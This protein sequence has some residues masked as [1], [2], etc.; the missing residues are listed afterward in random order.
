MTKK[1]SRKFITLASL[2]ILM[3]GMS[4]NAKAANITSLASGN[5]STTAT[6]VGGVVPV[7]GDVVTIA[8]GH[9]ITVTAN[10]A[11]ASVSFAG[12]T[13][14]TLTISSGFTLTVSGDVGIANTV[15]NVV[16]THTISG[17]GTLSCANLNITNGVGSGNGQSTNLTSNVTNLSVSGALTVGSNTKQGCTASIGGTTVN[18]G[19]VSV[20]N[21]NTNQAATLTISSTTLSLT[22]STIVRTQ[23][24]S[25][26]VTV[27][28]TSSTVNYTGAAQTVFA[29]TYTNLTLSGTEAKT[30]TGITVTGI[31]ELGGNAAVTTS[32]APTYGAAATLCYNKTAPFT[33]GVEWLAT[34]S[35]SGGVLIKNGGGAI[36]L[37]AAKIMNAPLNI[38]SGATLTAGSTFTLSGSGT[39]TNAGNL[40]LSA[41]GT[42]ASITRLTNSGTLN[43]NSTGTITTAVTNFTNT[44][45][46]NLSGSGAITGITNNAAGIVNH[47]GSS[48]IASFNNA[49]ATST[50]NIST[51]PTVPTFTTLTTSAAGNTVNYTGLGNQTV[52][53]QN[54]SNLGI[55]GSGTKTIGSATTIKAPGVVIVGSGA[56]L[57]TG[58]FLTLEATASGVA[59]IGN[60]A[61]T[62][63]GNTTVDIYIPSNKRAFR[64]MANPFSGAIGLASLIDDIFVTGLNGATNGFDPTTSNNP[65]AFSFAEGDFNGA[66]NSGWSALTSGSSTTN[67]PANS[68]LRIFYRGPRT[69]GTVVLGNGPPAPNEGIIDLTGLVNQGTKNIPMT[70]TS[71]NGSTNAGWNLIPN[72]YA[73]NVDIGT[74]VDANKNNIT[75]FSVWLPSNG[76]RGAYTTA[77]FG[78]SYI[79]PAGGAFFVKTAGPANF[80]FTEA[81]KTSSAPSAVLLKSDPLKLNAIQLD[82][83]SDDTIFWDS[84]VLRNRM[85]GLDGIDKMDAYKMQ[86]PDVNFYSLSAANDKLAIDHRNIV[87]ES[88]VNLGF[89]TTSDYHFTARVA[90]LDMP[91]FDVYFKDNYLKT[92]T[93]LSNNFKYDFSTNA[94]PLSK[95]DS[96]FQLYFT[97]MA[98][99]ILESKNNTNN[100]SVYPNPANDKVRIALT[101]NVSSA[102]YSYTVVNQLGQTLL[103]NKLSFDNG[104]SE[105]INVLDLPKGVYFMI[106]TSDAGTQT[107]KF[108]K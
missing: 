66:T 9:T 58:G 11:A 10:A 55:S 107:T 64:L 14:S 47:S 85:D 79:I 36:S 30:M 101:N 12:T 56:T 90:N 73:S 52:K 98:N 102:N 49:T 89:N 91:G 32:A 94:D 65:T 4:L 60:S 48:T 7:A 8:A 68:A 27:N 43:H 29:A 99:G 78:S 53:S 19:S 28:V 44:G 13:A 95:G 71:A 22:S 63:T 67:I 34:F 84:Y 81:N 54:Y 70:Y 15:I 77:S 105:E 108:C 20:T 69:Q 33:S 59:S 26:L 103:E 87:A 40:N 31:F 23:T 39:I 72:P 45:T 75:S 41:T 16:V 106:I 3:L 51:T 88:M 5:W 38:N 100:F 86:N 24:G 2:T 17:L 61:G 92:Q 74:I 46:I 6:W 1:S 37:N 35:A 76:T 18:I 97:K 96:R 104:T 80:T 82:I 42:A 57:A 83:K 50:L 25:G 21:N 62:I 93:L